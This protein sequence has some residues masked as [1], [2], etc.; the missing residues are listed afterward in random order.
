MGV[1]LQMISGTGE[2]QQTTREVNLLELTAAQQ[3]RLPKLYQPLPPKIGPR[4]ARE[5]GA[6]PKPEAVGLTKIPQQ[7]IDELQRLQAEKQPGPK[8]LQS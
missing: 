7:A 1:V 8:Q 4:T 6:A 3:D 5:I 2:E